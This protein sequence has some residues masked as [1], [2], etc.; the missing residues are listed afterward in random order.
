MVIFPFDVSCKRDSTRTYLNLSIISEQKL[1]YGL[2]VFKHFNSL[3]YPVDLGA[4]AVQHTSKLRSST[5]LLGRSPSWK[6]Q[7]SNMHQQS[8]QVTKTKQEHWLCK[9]EW[10]HAVFLLWQCHFSWIPVHRHR[11]FQNPTM[12]WLFVAD[13]WWFKQKW[14]LSKQHK[15]W[16]LTNTIL[17]SISSQHRILKNWYNWIHLRKHAVKRPQKTRCLILFIL[18]VH[19]RL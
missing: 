6:T 1:P 17:I 5:S 15:V 11:V 10:L 8:I 16:S 12:L 19:D 2:P 9:A 3:Y 14:V 18:Q 13:S 4:N 7:W